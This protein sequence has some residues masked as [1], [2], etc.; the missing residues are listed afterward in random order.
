MELAFQ[1][2]L[3][4]KYTGPTQRIRILSE[5]WVSTQV[6][7]PNCG[8]L[9]MTRY[10][11]NSPAADFFCSYCGEDYELKGQKKAFG[12]KV[13]DGAY[14]TMMERLTASNNPNLLLLAYDA[15]RLE[16][17][18]LVVV[19]RQFFIPAIIERRK[20]LSLGARRAGWI[21]CNIRL[22][23]IPD[24]GRIFMIRDGETEATTD[25]LA[26]WRQTLFLRQ[27]RD[28]G[29]RGWLLAVMKCIDRIP[30][31]TFSLADMYKFE[32]ELMT[33]FPEN[34]NV[35]PK[36]R[37]QLQVLRDM[38]YLAFLGNGTYE[39]AGRIA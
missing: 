33:V 17:T 25:V 4:T 37:Q 11:N 36:I 32:T 13:V 12:L 39:L 1:V 2:E 35:R 20:P 19:P 31:R 26:R 7:C 14:R 16:V 27:Q 6:Y 34:N 23:G 29:M 22:D 15:L 24:A 21:G 10:K 28:A 30:R 5:H 9:N 3:A 38:G 8:F 18:N